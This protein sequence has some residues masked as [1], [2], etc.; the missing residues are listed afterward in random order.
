MGRGQKI[1][2]TQFNLLISNQQMKNK[3]IFMVTKMQVYMRIQLLIPLPF[4]FIVSNI[5]LVSTL[6]NLLHL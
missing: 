4:G 5:A 2:V 1:N 6:I 3:N